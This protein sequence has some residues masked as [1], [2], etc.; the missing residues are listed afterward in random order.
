MFELMKYCK[1]IKRKSYIFYEQD[2][3]S[4]QC[5]SVFKH[6]HSLQKHVMTLGTERFSFGFNN[7][8]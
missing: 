3:F 8:L 5:F 1:E 2:V 4:N 6:F 7:S